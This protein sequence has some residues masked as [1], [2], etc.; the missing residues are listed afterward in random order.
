[1][2]H[3]QASYASTSHKNSSARRSHESV[4]DGFVEQ[5]TFEGTPTK[6]DFLPKNFE[7]LL[8]SPLIEHQE[9]ETPS[10]SDSIFDD[11][12]IGLARSESAK[13]SRRIP[14]N[15]PC[16]LSSS[17]SLFS[18]RSSAGNCFE[19]SASTFALSGARGFW[20]VATAD[21]KKSSR[22][23][24]GSISTTCFHERRVLRSESVD[25]QQLSL[26]HAKRRKRS[27]ALEMNRA[28]PF[29]TVRFSSCAICIVIVIHL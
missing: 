24:R 14:P 22:L 20:N 25:E 6:L 9:H 21:G 13:S 29:P 19:E 18:S 15:S 26:S 28:R 1:M 23:P 2:N 8:F 3:S 4:D 27:V 16:L 12:S 5:L 10:S 7:K 11:S 17:R